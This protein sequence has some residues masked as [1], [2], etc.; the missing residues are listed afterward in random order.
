MIYLKQAIVVEGK[1]DKIKLSNLIKTTIITTDGFRIF[2]NKEKR[3]LIKYLA[4]KNGVVILTD[5]DSAGQIIRNYIKSF[6]KNGDLFFA[7]VPQ[8]FGKERRK[9]NYSKEKILGVEGLDETTI[10][11]ALEKAGVFHLK[12]VENKFSLLNLMEVGLIGC[13]NSEKLRKE[14]LKQIK[15]P[16]YLSSKQLIEILNLNLNFDVFLTEIRKLKI[17]LNLI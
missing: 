9:K 5:S 4:R 12:S 10:L 8:I 17:R 1:F 7:Y 15:F 11:D 16:E 14:F 6:V 3:N 13:E 2:K